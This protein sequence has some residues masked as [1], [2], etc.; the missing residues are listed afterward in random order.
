MKSSRSLT[1]IRVRVEWS[2][3][4][5]SFYHSILVSILPIHLA[6]PLKLDI[7]QVEWIIALSKSTKPKDTFYFVFF[8]MGMHV[9]VA[10]GDVP[11][12]NMQSRRLSKT[13]QIMTLD[14]FFWPQ[15][16][17]QSWRR[18]QQPFGAQQKLKQKHN[19]QH[20]AIAV[21]HLETIH[22]SKDRLQ[23]LKSLNCNQ[24]QRHHLWGLYNVRKFQERIYIS[25]LARRDTI[26]QFWSVWRDQ[27]QGL[28]QITYCSR[29][30]VNV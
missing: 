25:Q 22:N 14:I 23:N 21:Q 6:W 4:L 3:H 7:W 1:F 26:K 10:R 30:T 2:F 12:S 18:E 11:T 13:Q 16:P 28:S 24:R 29:S 19:Q 15:K 20:Y 8:L 17:N 27:M 5:F 9:V